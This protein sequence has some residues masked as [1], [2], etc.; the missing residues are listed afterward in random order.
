MLGAHQKA[1]FETFGFLALRQV[2]PPDKMEAIAREHEAIM[3]ADRQDRPFPADQRQ[4][5]YGGVEQS[6]FLRQLLEDDTIYGA[7]E[8]LLGPGFIWQGS[9]VNLFVG[10]TSWHSGAEYGKILR[11][12]KMALYLD[13][14]R[15]ETG[16]L[17]VV[18]GSHLEPLHSSL[19]PLRNAAPDS[20][21]FDV[22]PDEV[23]NM[24]VESDR[25]DVLIFTEAVW[26]GSFGGR[27]GRRMFTLNFM[28]K[29]ETREQFEYVKALYKGDLEFM[30]E[31]QH[32]QRDWIY[33]EE[34]LGSESPRIK[35]MAAPLIELGL[36]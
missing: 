31:Q 7:M 36:R 21:P 20:P 25:G 22:A 16:C 5:V 30:K 14:V 17:R 8:L 6:E 24:A 12:I 35:S 29:P 18:P 9:D 2:F 23:P 34:F 33:G 28:A 1:H 26:H 19:E 4:A 13:P 32:T 11:G 10:D 27:T 3:T 15:K